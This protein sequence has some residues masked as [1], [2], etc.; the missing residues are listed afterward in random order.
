VGHIAQDSA[1]GFGRNMVWSWREGSFTLRLTHRDPEGPDD[2]LR[3]TTDGS[4]TA[5]EL[6]Y[7]ASGPDTP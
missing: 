7:D 5:L 4:A 6:W 3:P 2:E 1:Q